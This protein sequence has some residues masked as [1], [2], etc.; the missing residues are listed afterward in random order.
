VENSESPG[1]ASKLFHSV[2]KFFVA[3]VGA[4]LVGGIINFLVL[5]VF[6]LSGRDLLD[7][8][9]FPRPLLSLLLALVGGFSWGASFFAILCRIMPEKSRK[10]AIVLFVF[11]GVLL[12]FG[13]C[14]A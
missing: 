4:C 6:R 5:L 14:Q 1:T 2:F 13:I 10:I 9:V 11:C 3:I 8:A 7:E 12:V